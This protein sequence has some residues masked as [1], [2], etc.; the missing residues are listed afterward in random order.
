MSNVSSGLMEYVAKQL[1]D[2]RVVLAV[3]SKKV[4]NARLDR[5]G[6]FGYQSVS[7]CELRVGPFGLEQGSRTAFGGVELGAEQMQVVGVRVMKEGSVPTQ[8][9][10]D[11][12]QVSQSCV[13]VR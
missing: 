4:G 3:K 7:G 12:R 8:A 9:G 11:G 2:A 1:N 5:V 6:A 13:A 10:L